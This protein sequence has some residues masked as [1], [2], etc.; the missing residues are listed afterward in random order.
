MRE[1]GRGRE[2]RRKKEKKLKQVGLLTF[3]ST[4]S[5]DIDFVHPEYDVT[6]LDLQKQQTPFL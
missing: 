6:G 1:K 5:V 3:F 2:K 4:E